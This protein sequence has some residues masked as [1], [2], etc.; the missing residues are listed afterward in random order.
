MWAC[1]RAL[2]SKLHPWS[3]AGR[4]LPQNKCPQR[5]LTTVM[6]SPILFLHPSAS[7][8]G[9][10]SC[11]NIPLSVIKQPRCLTPKKHKKTRLVFAYGER[12]PRAGIAESTEEYKAI[13]PLIWAKKRGHSPA[14]P[15]DEL[16]VPSLE[17]QRLKVGV[18]V[19]FCSHRGP[20]DPLGLDAPKSTSSFVRRAHLPSLLTL[21]GSLSRRILVAASFLSNAGNTARRGRT[22]CTRSRNWRGRS[23]TGTKQMSR[24]ATGIAVML[25]LLCD[26]HTATTIP[27]YL[28]TSYHI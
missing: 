22:S 26:I 13:V 3:S 27:S 6:P 12:A 24:K 2:K 19:E 14:Q 28:I 21:T 1:S 4:C 11:C 18:V 10:G 8:L 5:H 7:H 17:K 23:S 9:V 16:P 25:I 15:L 20:H